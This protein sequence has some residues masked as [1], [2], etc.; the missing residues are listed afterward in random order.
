MRDIKKLLDILLDQYENNRIGGIQR[1]GIC[2]AI[3]ELSEYELINS[4]EDYVLGAYI[5]KNRPDW[6]Y[7]MSY[8]WPA[9]ET[10]PR[11]KF[12]KQLIY[13]LE[14]ETWLDKLKRK[15]GL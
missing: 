3:G 2:W 13:E 4:H 5:I 11:I 14:N 6:S 15:S 10:K 1:F 12:L 9:G 8:W 7:G